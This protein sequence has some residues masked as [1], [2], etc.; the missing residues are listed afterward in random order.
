MKTL[1]T[2][3]RGALL[4]ALIPVAGFAQT[5]ASQTSYKLPAAGARL[6]NVQAELQQHYELKADFGAAGDGATNDSAAFLAGVKA[7]QTNGM[8]IH[9]PGGNFAITDVESTNTGGFSLVCDGP[10]QT[11]FTRHSSALQASTPLLKLTNAASVNIHGCGWNE[12]GD[13]TNYTN[14]AS[15]VY[16]STVGDVTIDNNY[17]T[18]AQSNAFIIAGATGPVKFTRNTC[19]YFWNA[20]LAASGS[21]T[22]ASKVYLNGLIATD[23]HCAHGHFCILPSV[24]LNNV[25]VSGN[26]MD[27][28]SIALV[29][30]VNY[31]TVSHNVVNGTTDYGFLPLTGDCIFM[32]GIEHSSVSGNYLKGCVGKGI[33]YNGSQLTVGTTEQLATI[34]ASVT[35]NFIEGAT[36]A[37][38]FV[39]GGSFDNS[40]QGSQISVK[41]NTIVN[42]L[43]GVTVTASDAVDIEG[44]H[45]D[46][47]TTGGDAI[48]AVTNFRYANNKLHN[49]SSTGGQPA[50]TTNTS[51]NG[52]VQGNTITSSG[53]KSNTFCWSDTTLAAGTGTAISILPD[54]IFT[55]CTPVNPSAASAPTLGTWATGAKT[56][57]FAT[58]TGSPAY[59]VNTAGG[60]PGTW[61]PAGYIGSAGVPTVSSCGT[62]TVAGGGNNNRFAISLSGGITACTVAFGTP[63]FSTAPYCSITMYGSAVTASVHAGTLTSTAMQVDFSGSVNG[64]FAMVQCQ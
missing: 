30:D 5:G 35:E 47:L 34:D 60:T 56:T 21:G 2:Q 37:G 64:V 57:T 38:I 48:A 10:K 55:N 25:T 23:N 20:C 26:V 15:T 52:I 28:S 27:K 51:L 40:I 3:F 62:S 1:F 17:S 24:F 32:E 6:A 39:K 9:A 31:S 46:T 49:T 29:Q 4:L 54:N 43:G 53:G 19:T 61:Q 11:T 16:L 13:G 44:N 36:D 58:T 18:L 8:S 12:L 14:A 22:V 7:A 50:V 45:E 63:A 33:Y 59:Y 41:E 42:G